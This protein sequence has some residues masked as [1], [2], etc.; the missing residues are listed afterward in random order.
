MQVSDRI[1]PRVVEIA[2]EAL[3][4]EKNILMVAGPAG[5]GGAM[6]VLIRFLDNCGETRENGDRKGLGC[7]NSTKHGS[8]LLCP[9]DPHHIGR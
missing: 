3:H 1:L 6:I 8:K 4:S 5:A 9:N 2:T 7:P